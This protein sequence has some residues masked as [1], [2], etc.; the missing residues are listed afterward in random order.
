M[1]QPT[2][3]PLPQLIAD[4][5]RDMTA[6]QI[7]EA[8]AKGQS[9]ELLGVP[10]PPEPFTPTDEDGKAR[11]ITADDLARWH[12]SRLSL[13]GRQGSCGTWGLHRRR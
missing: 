7:T 2:P 3:E 1:S 13:R 4:D 10:L 11:A 6:E 8:R 5:L 12:L 9:N